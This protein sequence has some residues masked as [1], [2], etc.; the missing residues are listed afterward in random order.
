METTNI[1]LKNLPSAD[2]NQLESGI[3]IEDQGK[4]AQILE[5]LGS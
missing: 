5:D 4:L 3:F 2:Q 1:E